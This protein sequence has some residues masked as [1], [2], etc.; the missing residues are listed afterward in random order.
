M[1]RVHCYQP[2]QHTN[3]HVHTRLLLMHLE[4]ILKC[5][6][7][8]RIQTEQLGFPAHPITWQGTLDPESRH[9]GL[10]AGLPPQL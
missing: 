2:V 7:A 3:K 9:F 1:R 6:T 10:R 5:L 8:K 4:A